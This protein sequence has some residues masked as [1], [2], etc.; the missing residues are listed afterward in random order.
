MEFMPLDTKNTGM[1]T[2]S[3][4]PAVWVIPA[5]LRQLADSGDAELVE[6][7]I[8]IFQTDTAERLEVMRRA[9]DAR[10]F[11]AV[12]AEAH[13]I[14]GSAVQVGA[15]RLAEFCRQMELEVRKNPP[16]DLARPFAML[17][18]SFDEVCGVIASAG[19]QNSRQLP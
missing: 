16:V 13:T 17:L 3:E 9:I 19:N 7:L 2:G 15:N 10:D 18:A 8:A 11:V 6:E 5:A 14:K 1:N 4:F 12:G